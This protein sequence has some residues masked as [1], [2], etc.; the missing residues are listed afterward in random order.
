MYLILLFP[1]YLYVLN[2]S[3]Y[4]IK[5][6]IMQT[7][8]STWNKQWNEQWDSL[9]FC[10]H[11]FILGISRLV[12]SSTSEFVCFLS[13]FLSPLS[14]NNFLIPFYTHRHWQAPNNFILSA[15]KEQFQV[16]L[17]K[18]INLVQEVLVKWL[19]SFLLILFYKCNDPL[20]FQ[21]HLNYTFAIMK[22][23]VT[24]YQLK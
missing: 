9:S 6:L 8:S 22:W 2:W 13:L 15:Y 23:Y 14:S 5:Q 17:V 7:V 10:Q 19:E 4:R 12:S 20:S 3:H 18:Y 16:F 11:E 24:I 1:S 21:L